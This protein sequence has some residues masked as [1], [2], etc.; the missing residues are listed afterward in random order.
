MCVSREIA[1]GKW[2]D[3]R[4]EDWIKK[5][6]SF[7]PQTN[8]DAQESPYLCRRGGIKIV[9]NTHHKPTPKNFFSFTEECVYVCVF[10]VCLCG[11]VTFNLNQSPHPNLHISLIQG[12]AA[13]L[14]E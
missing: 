5:K 1:G 2:R 6:K 14:F 10:V 3:I 4:A 11:N 12:P 13:A 7:R 8:K 9:R